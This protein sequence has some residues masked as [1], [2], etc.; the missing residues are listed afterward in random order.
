MRNS[1]VVILLMLVA[2]CVGNHLHTVTVNVTLRNS[3]TNDLNWV[4][5]K[6]NGPYVPG[7][8]LSHGV[9][10]MAVDAEWSN[11]STGE[12]TFIDRETEHPYSIKLS[13]PEV[14]AKVMSGKCT[15][16]EIKILSYEKA[17]VSCK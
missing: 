5:L 14:N 8:V 2:G 12:L 13:F 6:W 11:V 1:L 10:K 4:E 7:E 16:V 9:Y 17:E 15:D 3:S